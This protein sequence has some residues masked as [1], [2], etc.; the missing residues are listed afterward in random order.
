MKTAGV[1]VR[2]ILA[3]NRTG[4]QYKVALG[5]VAGFNAASVN[6]I[7]S[8]YSYLRIISMQIFLREKI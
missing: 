2:R 3:R 5:M 8:A 1:P 4:A 6:T 7:S